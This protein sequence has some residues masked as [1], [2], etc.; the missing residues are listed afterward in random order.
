MDTRG[1]LFSWGMP[2]GY[3]TSAGPFL[4][5]STRVPVLSSFHWQ[6]IADLE[7]TKL[8]QAAYRMACH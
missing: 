1:T 8:V 7:P 4:A 6:T 2:E 5:S 3:E